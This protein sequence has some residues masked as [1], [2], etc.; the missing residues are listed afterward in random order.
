V[1][2]TILQ[3]TEDAIDF[4]NSRD[5]P[6]CLTAFSN[7]EAFRQHSKNLLNF[8]S[9]IKPICDVV[10]NNTQSGAAIGNDCLLHAGCIVLP[11]GGVGLSGCTSMD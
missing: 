5:T 8:M 2:D 10:F 9:L 3:T 1:V 11:F 4:I 6:L 7:S